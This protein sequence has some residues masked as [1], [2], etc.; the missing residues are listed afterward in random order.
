VWTLP[1]PQA[2]LDRWAALL[3]PGGRLVLVEGRWGSP[4][5][6]CEE[7]DRTDDGDYA[8]VRHALPW[9]GGVDAETLVAA[10]QRRFS[11]VE[12]YDLGSESVLWGHVVADER[13]AVVA[14]AG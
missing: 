7:G 9:Y 8:S 10:L 4:S 3:R 1:D 5:Q 2:A 13:F 14:H 12:R 11:H 6:C